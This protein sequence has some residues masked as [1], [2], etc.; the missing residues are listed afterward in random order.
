MFTLF[1]NRIV[2]IDEAAQI[3]IGRHAF[4]PH[5]DIFGFQCSRQVVQIDYT[6]ILEVAYACPH[7]RCLNGVVVA[8]VGTEYR[9]IK[10]FVFLVLIVSCSVEIVHLQA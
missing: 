8:V 9:S 10:E 6:P 7:K 5:R 4:H 3:A 2:V 1:G